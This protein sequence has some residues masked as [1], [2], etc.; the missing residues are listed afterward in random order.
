MSAIVTYCSK[1]KKED[2]V[3][4]PAI[5]RYITKRIERIHGKAIKEKRPM[6]ILSGLLGL[7]QPQTPI[8]WYDKQLVP[9]DIGQ[10]VNLI[11]HQL[12]QFKISAIEYF[13]EDVWLKPEIKPYQDLLAAACM[14]LDIPMKV[15]K[16]EYDQGLGN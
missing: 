6:F 14:R 5:E 16:A 3:P 7:I 13:T 4:L 10:M 2:S 8:M 11:S 9:A 12:L 15:L 1:N